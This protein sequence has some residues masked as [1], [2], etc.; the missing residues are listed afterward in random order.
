MKKIILLCLPILVG[1]LAFAQ[2]TSPVKWTFTSKKLTN[3]VYEV[4]LKASIESGWHMY[5]QSIPDGGPIRTTFKFSQDPRLAL[6]GT[7]SGPAPIKKYEDAFK[8]NVTYFENSVVFIQKIKV[9]GSTKFKLHGMLEYMA[10]SKDKILPA[11][12]VDFSVS[13]IL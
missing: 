5:S 6:I 9:K 12:S 4:R 10:A 3:D 1:L 11:E 13:V 2:K 8:M 7:T